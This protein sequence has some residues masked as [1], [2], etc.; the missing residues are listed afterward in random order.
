MRKIHKKEHN[1]FR[2]KGGVKGGSGG[3]WLSNKT[4]SPSVQS[5]EE[6]KMPTKG[7]I[8]KRGAR[9]RGFSSVQE[10]SIDQINEEA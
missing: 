10:D 5:L 4:R 1:Y 9:N 7:S 6:S 2:D 3:G 8:R